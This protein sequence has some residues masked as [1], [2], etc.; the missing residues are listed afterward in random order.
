M[1]VVIS[2]SQYKRLIE[3]EKQK[4]VLKKS[5]M[6]LNESKIEKFIQKIID[7]ALEDLRDST[8]EM[9]LGEMDELD[10]I[11]S[12]DNIK[13]TNVVKDKVFVIHVDLYVNTNRDDFDN[14]IYTI[15]Y[16]VGRFLG[17]VEIMVDNI[18]DTRTFGPGIDW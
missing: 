7:N 12:V 9:G 15:E 5:T 17:N 16:K 18:I 10:E 1:K 14:I 4:V 8:E 11:N 13:V 2:E 3:T 6:G